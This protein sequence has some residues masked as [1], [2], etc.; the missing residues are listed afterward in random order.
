MVIKIKYPDIGVC[1]LS[2]VLCPRYYTDGTSRCWGC[3]TP[4]RMGAICPIT[5][6]ALNKKGVEFCWKCG[7]SQ[8]C[9]RWGKLRDFGKQ[10]DS[11]KCYQ[12]LEDDIAF[13]QQHDVAEFRIKQQIRADLLTE[14]LRDFNEGR[15]KR[16]YCIAATVMDI[17]ELRESLSKAKKTSAGLGMKEKA[18]VLHSILDEIAERKGYYLKLRK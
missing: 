10:H 4:S 17:D 2:C 1:G 7:E 9:P 13:I 18:K 15:S 8:S 12:T 11:P 5:N 14:M 3:K 6:C 16:Y